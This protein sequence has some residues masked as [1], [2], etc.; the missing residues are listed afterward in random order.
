[1]TLPLDVCICIH[2]PRRDILDLVL[3]SLARQTAPKALYRVLLVDNC[4]FPPLDSRPCSDLRNAGLSCE[5][6]REPLRGISHARA[7][8]IADTQVQWLLFVDDDN[9]LAPDYIAN[10]IIR[11]HEG[12]GCFG[13]KLLLPAYLQPPHWM[14]QLLPFLGNKDHGDEPIVKTA[15][16]WGPWEPP[17]AGAFVHRSLLNLYL[18][19][20]ATHPEVH[21]LGRKGTSSLASCEDSLIMRGA[22]EL[23]RAASRGVR[24]G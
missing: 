4:S 12:L 19:K 2:N 14:S 1:M 23:D 20:A 18:R 24:F 22:F 3:N 10:D 21:T 5:L 16:H 17:T 9:E 7:R 15:N 13:G 6:T 8:A 11:R